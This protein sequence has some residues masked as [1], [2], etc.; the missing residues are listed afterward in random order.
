MTKEHVTVI[1][2]D[3]LSGIRVQCS[4]CSGGVHMR[5]NGSAGK[6]PIVCPCCGKQWASKVQE[7]VSLVNVI[8]GLRNG[9]PNSEFTIRFEVDDG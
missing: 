1:G 9:D 2:I 7:W 4:H 8:E 5:L 3:D 6:I